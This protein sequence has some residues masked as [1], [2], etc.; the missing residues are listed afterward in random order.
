MTRRR[1]RNGS[2][3][4]IYWCLGCKINRGASRCVRRRTRSRTRLLKNERICSEDRANSLN[5]FH[6]V[7]LPI[8][9]MQIGQVNHSLR[10]YMAMVWLYHHFCC[11]CDDAHRWAR[12]MVVTKINAKRHKVSITLIEHLNRSIKFQE[13]LR[14]CREA[15]N[16]R[17]KIR[18]CC[19]RSFSIAGKKHRSILTEARFHLISS[20][21]LKNLKTYYCRQSQPKRR[22]DKR[23]RGQKRTN[24]CC[25]AGS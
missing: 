5:H 6:K 23:Y 10:I 18:I 2:L 24:L 11:R 15:A 16:A 20:S 12:W 7:A 21:N 13:F 22:C 14:S 3:V 8:P 4:S 9:F 1:S 25:L 17:T 19:H